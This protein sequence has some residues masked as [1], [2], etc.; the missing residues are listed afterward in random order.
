MSTAFFVSAAWL[1]AT[2]TS[3][4][5]AGD[6]PGAHAAAADEDAAYARALEKRAGDVLGVLKLDDPAK[7]ARV[8]EAVI[9]QYRGLRRLHDARDA[10]IKAL[11]GRPVPDEAGPGK[12]IEAERARADAASSAL[13]DRFLA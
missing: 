1:A 3:P 5:L 9:N 6:E 7:A 4:T 2:V 12:R 13:N 8:R 10:N 11:Q